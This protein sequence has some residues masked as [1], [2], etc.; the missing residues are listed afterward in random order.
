ML[1]KSIAV[2]LT[3]V[4]C[5]SVGTAYAQQTEDE[6]IAR[7]LQK[8][9]EKHTAKLGWASLQFSVDRIN[10]NN[11]YNSFASHESNQFSEGSLSWLGQGYSIGAEFGLI[12]KQGVTW[13][14]GGEYWLK[15]TDGISGSPTYLPAGTAV[16]N[17]S[18]EIQVIGFTTGVQYFLMGKPVPTTKLNKMAVR[19]GGSIGYYAATWDLWPEYQ[20][21][22]LSTASTEA[23][24]VSYK[25]TA[26]GFFF[27]IGI[28]YP[29]N[30]WD[31]GLG[32]DMGYMILNFNNVAWYNSNDEEIIASYNGS[33]DGRVD[34]D[35]S[36]VRGRVEL[37]RYFSW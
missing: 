13:S 15:M 16:D 37:K 32:V 2:V 9:E 34:L 8:T 31:C 5:L 25:G 22:N 10:R 19:V 11:T 27:N 17:P 28:D 29:L 4:F 36:G 30:F 21:L 12:F 35:F 26:P 7:Y 33:D 18:S 3:L 14:L 23:N 20:N 6:I 24:N 1:K